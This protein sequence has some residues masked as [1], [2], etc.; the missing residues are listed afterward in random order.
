LARGGQAV[1]TLAKWMMSQRRGK[2]ISA[3]GK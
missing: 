1:D 3:R 2:A